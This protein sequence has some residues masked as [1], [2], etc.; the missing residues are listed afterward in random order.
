VREFRR[1]LYGD[2]LGPWL[3][4]LEDR[5]NGFLLP[6]IE[7][8]PADLYVEFNINE[9]LQGSFEEQAQV[10]SMA[11][12]GPYM[13]RNEYRARQNLPPIDGADELIVPMNVTEG[14][15]PSP[16]TPV[17]S[18]PP[19]RL[20]APGRP[21]GTQRAARAHS[22]AGKTMATQS[23]HDKTVAV[24][25]RF[26]ERQGRVVLS[27]L[28]TK[29]RAFKAGDSWWNAERWNKELS[30][31]L[32]EVSLPVS[33]EIGSDA[34]ADLTTE[35]KY[36]TERT[37]PFLSKVMDQ[38]AESMNAATKDQL[39]AALEAQAEADAEDEEA[40]SPEDVYSDDAIG[41]RSE[42]GA[43]TILTT[44]A[45]FAMAEAGQQAAPGGGAMKTWVVT[46]SNS[47]HPEMDGETVPVEDTFSNGA[48]WP[49]DAA[50]GPDD[51]AGCEC[52]LE[53]SIP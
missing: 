28:N 15:Q 4:Q 47:R 37:V 41:F 32:L 51:T 49:G 48:Q 22:P 31:D 23:Q 39:D 21:W 42:V 34:I 10:A 11:V 7:Q 12:G 19:M 36:D 1:M 44:V 53:I 33:T 18:A 43:A 6:K 27:Q 35:M 26:Y 3:S 40:L 25:T 38:R 46:S 17:L 45:G 5:I 2:T 8:N 9:K 52:E 13:T 29:S 20:T 30:S 50:L 24:L 14:G 16:Q